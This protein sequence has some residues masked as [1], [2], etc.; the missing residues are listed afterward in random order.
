[1][2]RTGMRVAATALAVVLVAGACGASGGDG[3][4]TPAD[5]SAPPP[6][7]EAVPPPAEPPTP[8]PA[9]EPAPAEPAAPDPPPPPPPEPAEQSEEPGQEPEEPGEQPEEPGEPAGV[10]TGPLDE[11]AVV[12]LLS[13]IAAAEAGVT[14]SLVEMYLSLSLSMDGESAGAASD[15]P[16]TVL[17]SVGDLTHTWYDPAA[18]AA[19]EAFEGGPPEDLTPVEFI[20]DAGAQQIFVKLEPL[21]GEFDIEELGLPEGTVVGDDV[22]ALWGKVATGTGDPELDGMLEMLDFVGQTAYSDFLGLLQAAGDGDAVLEAV[23]EGPGETAGV[24]TTRYRFGLDLGAL[25]EDLPA[26]VGGFL[27]EGPTAGVAP[28]GFL[29]GIGPLRAELTLQVDGD[30]IVRELGFHLD[31]GAIMAAIFEGFAEGSDGAEGFIPEIE[32]LLSARFLTLAVNDPALVVT[33]PDESM[34]VDLGEMLSDRAAY[35][36]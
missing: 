2:L 24:P 8:E 3:V 33:V 17:T 15:L 18:L 12:E 35:D 26:F 11:A 22:S 28:E 34:V 25:T 13:A 9:P 14:S 29:E 10:A 19:V 1:M 30:G 20:I 31:L 6:A 23:G 36:A 16:L 4:A 27:G 7:T 21:L 32:Y 5:T